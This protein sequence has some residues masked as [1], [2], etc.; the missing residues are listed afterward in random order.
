MFTSME[1]V[2]PPTEYADTVFEMQ[3]WQPEATVT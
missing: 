3:C 1:F 2:T